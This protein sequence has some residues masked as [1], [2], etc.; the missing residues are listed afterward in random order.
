MKEKAG[1]K[2]EEDVAAL[3]KAMEGLGES[4]NNYYQYFIAR[5]DIIPNQT[6]CTIFL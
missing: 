6:R 4:M 5:L 3:R 2:V 1:F